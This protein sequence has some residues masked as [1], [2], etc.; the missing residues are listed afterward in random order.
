MRLNVVLDDEDFR[1][2]C[3]S[4]LPTGSNISRRVCRTG[5]QQRLLNRQSTSILRSIAPDEN[6]QLDLTNFNG[7][8]EEIGAEM[9]A[10]SQAFESAVLEAVNTDVELNQQVIRLMALK[11]AIENYETPRER[12]QRELDELIG[13]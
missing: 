9:A 6:G 8:M 7:S 10:W 5:F 12:R 1:I 4:E 3:D 11:S 13:D 2:V